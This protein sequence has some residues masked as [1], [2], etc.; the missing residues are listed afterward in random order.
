MS[1]RASERSDLGI[2]TPAHRAGALATLWSAFALAACATAEP[3]AAPTPIPA[4]F[5]WALPA[6]DTASD[7]VDDGFA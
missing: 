3:A 7:G 1:E 4:G 5:S 2:R 6:E